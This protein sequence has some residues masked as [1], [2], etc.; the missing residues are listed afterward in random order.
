MR[1]I[2]EPRSAPHLRSWGGL[3]ECI[4][5][6]GSETIPEWE[7]LLAGVEHVSGHEARAESLAEMAEAG[8]VLSSYRGTGFHLDSDYA[9]VGGFQDGV[10]LGLVLGAVVVGRTAVVVT[11]PHLLWTSGRYRYGRLA[12]LA[13]Y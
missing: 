11:W 3:P 12:D 5:G 6:Q 7:G 1:S 4:E 2:L 13:P 9:A 10:Y 8:Q